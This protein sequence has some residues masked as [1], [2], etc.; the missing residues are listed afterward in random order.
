LEVE[1]FIRD[2]AASE[3]PPD[4]QEA[5]GRYVEW[6]AFSARGRAFVQ[7]ASRDLGLQPEEICRDAARS[8]F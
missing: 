6:N 1:A 4:W 3:G 8:R 2:L 5:Y 7:T